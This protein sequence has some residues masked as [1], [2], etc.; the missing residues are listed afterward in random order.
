MNYKRQL[1][2]SL[3]QSMFIYVHIWSYIIIY[4][5][6]MPAVSQNH[7]RHGPCGPQ[8]RWQRH[9]P[10]RRRRH[11]EPIQ[12][13]SGPQNLKQ[14]TIERSQM[15]NDDPWWWNIYLQNWVIYGVNVGKYTIHG[16][17]GNSSWW[18]I[19][20]SQLGWDD[21]IPNTTGKINSVPKHHD[22]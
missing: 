10:G 8:P 14:C 20:I 12:W 19:N 5:H 13:I 21:E 4:D 9:G 1:N 15:I 7:G 17:S 18:L 3:N 6:C 16:S 2:N 11:G 22:C